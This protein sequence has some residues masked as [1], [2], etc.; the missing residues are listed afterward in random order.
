MA[1]F[2]HFESHR[3]ALRFPKC[4]FGCYLLRHIADEE[5]EEGTVGNGKKGK[6]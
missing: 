5:E 2:V 1:A 6:E 3:A 4:T